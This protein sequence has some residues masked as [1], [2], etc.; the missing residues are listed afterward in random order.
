MLRKKPYNA[1]VKISSTNKEPDLQKALRKLDD[2]LKA[3]DFKKEL[4]KRRY[5]VPPGERRRMKSKIARARARYEARK[6]KS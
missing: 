6:N 4:D 5:F 2:Q 3:E 1:Y